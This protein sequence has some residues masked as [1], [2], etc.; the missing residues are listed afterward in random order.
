ML[1]FNSRSQTALHV[2]V[3]IDA[4]LVARQTASPP[5]TY[6]GGSRLGHACE[7]ALQFEFVKAPKDEGADFGLVHAGEFRLLPVEGATVADLSERAAG[8]AQV[9]VDEDHPDGVEQADGVGDAVVELRRRGEVD[10]GQG[11]GDGLAPERARIDT[12]DLKRCI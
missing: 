4:A 6:L 9:M 11:A 1:D 10:H 12:V 7:R 8:D 3:A 2:N 5:R